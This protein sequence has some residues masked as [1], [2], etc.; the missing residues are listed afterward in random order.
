MRQLLVLLAASA[1]TGCASTALTEPVVHASPYLALYRL[2]GDVGLQSAGGQDNAAASMDTFGQARR[3]DDVGIRVDVGDGF[4]GLRADYYKLDMNTSTS[5]QLA[6]DWGALLAGDSVSM[7]ASMDELRLGYVE[8]LVEF[9]TKWRAEDL[10]VR[11]GAGGALAIRDARLRGR[12]LTGTRTQD[13][14]FS[15]QLAYVAIRARAAWQRL[16]IDLDYALAPEALAIGGDVDGVSHDFEA[17]LSY[18]LP[19]GDMSFFAG[20]RRNDVGARGDAD[21]LDFTSD[22][23]IDGFQLG[24]LVTF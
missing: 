9:Q 7:F 14:G 21:G 1:F 22:L 24:V 2:R 13:L 11:L 17:R 20:Y 16:A 6:E 5:G 15:H 19:Q 4:C 12:E 10:R 18:Q 23:V 3:R 8:E